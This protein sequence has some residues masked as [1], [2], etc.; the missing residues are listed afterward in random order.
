MNTVQNYDVPG[1]STTSVEPSAHQIG[2]TVPCP[3]LTANL[4][5][6]RQYLDQVFYPRLFPV[7]TAGTR[8][9]DATKA[10]DS[11]FKDFSIDLSDFDLGL[12]EI[13]LGFEDPDEK[14]PEDAFVGYTPVQ[15]VLMM[16]RLFVIFCGHRQN[17]W[18][19]DYVA[20]LLHF[21][22]ECGETPLILQLTLREPE[23]MR[24]CRPFCS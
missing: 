14:D 7:D 9:D 5:L 20:E 12:D 1:T 13:D 17:D 15:R 16:H 18:W 23:V 21:F 2:Q 4:A 6:L 8:P 11:P 10:D 22:G 24:A 3:R 19:S